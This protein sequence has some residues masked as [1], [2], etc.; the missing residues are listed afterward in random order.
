VRNE[1]TK[2]RLERTP[3]PLGCVA[4][5]NRG[6]LLCTGDI[7]FSIDDDAEFSSPHIVEQT[8]AG[9]SH[10]R[11]AAVAIPYIEPYKSNHEFQKA[12]DADAIWL[13]DCFRGTSHALRRDVFV[14]LG[15]YR[16]H[17]VH[18]GE[19]MDFCI[20]LLNHGFVVR[21]GFGD[22]VI[23]HAFPKRDLRRMDFYGRRND[24]L[25]AWR[26]VPMPYLPIHLLVTTFNGLNWAFSAKRPHAMI[27]GM[28]SGYLDVI[29]N[30]GWHQPVSQDV[31][32]L[33]RLLKKRGPIALIEVE[34]LLATYP[35]PRQNPR[36]LR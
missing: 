23:H 33:H 9:F 27:R 6:A 13:I 35:L 2:V 17:I 24:V 21:V 29:S 22:V 14:K 11:I 18:Q 20:R 34:P 12:S 15:G 25:F 1:F 5:R 26:N 4:Q 36:P 7:I 31:Y 3:V 19:E 16:E 32:R 28:L 10:P 30:W 8:L